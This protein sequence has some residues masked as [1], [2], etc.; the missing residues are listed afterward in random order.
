[1]SI[2]T[3][4]VSN[5]S[6]A[7]S[8]G[9]IKHFFSFSGDIQYI[10]MQRESESSRLAYVTFKDSQEADTAVL[11]SGAAIYDLSVSI[12]PDENYLLPP[13]AIPNSPPSNSNSAVKKAEDVVT[14]MLARG[15]V[16]GKDALNKA[17]AF[18]ERHH[19]MSNASDTVVALDRRMGLREKIGIGT[20]IVN[21]K[22]KEVDERFQVSE[23][24][25]SAIG[26]A[27]QKASSAG[28]ALMN[29]HYISAGAS[30]VSGALNVVA[31]AAE[32]LSHITK[33]KVDRAEEEK[34][35]VYRHRTEIVNDFSCIHLNEPS[36]GE[37]RM[38]PIDTADEGK[39]GII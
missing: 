4:K 13:E 16:L 1:M 15:F 20:S 32:D 29:N 2:K 8:E 7:A 36:T 23:K 24:T 17:R 3:V 35:T 14:S 28:S 5:I 33:E 25:R 37:P 11:L 30:W 6:L 12:A 21:E 27:E 10:E 38:V 26:L 22:M 31:K 34:E 18:D 39:L 9:D 19:L